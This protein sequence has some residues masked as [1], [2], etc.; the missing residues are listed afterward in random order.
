MLVCAIGAKLLV[1]YGLAWLRSL[2]V[3]ASCAILALVSMALLTPLLGLEPLGYDND[4]MWWARLVV[5][6]VIFVML[7]GAVATWLVKVGP[8]PTGR[9]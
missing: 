4:P 7:V 9:L 5:T 1:T 3:T 8:V 6:C 2:L